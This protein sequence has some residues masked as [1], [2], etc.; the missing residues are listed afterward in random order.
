MYGTT[1][2]N[3]SIDSDIAVNQPKKNYSYYFIVGVVALIGLLG[4]TTYSAGFVS[5]SSSK[6]ISAPINQHNYLSSN[7]LKVTATNE[8]G[9]FSAPYPWMDDVDG[10][11]LV[12]PYK[13][14]TLTLSGSYIEDQ[15]YTYVWEID[16]FEYKPVGSSVVITGPVPGK[17]TVKVNALDDSKSIV[18]TYT[19]LLVSKYVKREI[20]SLTVADR[21]KM[22]DAAY[23]MWAYDQETGVAKYG[24][25]FTSIEKFVQIHSAASNDIMCDQFHEGTG[26]IT[27]HLAMGLA[28]EA[29]LRAVDPSVTLPYWD[30]TIEGEKIQNAGQN[31]S[32]F[33]EFSPA[34]TADWFGSV[35]DDNHIQDGRWAHT[36]MPLAPDDETTQNSYGFIRSYWNNNPDPEISR[37]LFDAC[38][39]EP[40]HKAIPACKTHLAILNG[41]SLGMFQLLSPG[42]GHG[43]MHV[44]IGGVWGGCTEAYSAFQAKWGDLLR[45]TLSDSEIEATGLDLRSFK[46]KWGETE[47]R[48]TMIEKA[49]MG[50]Y[51]H[52]YRSFWRS[53]MCA[54][55]NTPAL[56]ECPESCDVD[57]TPFEECAC[58]VN[59]LTNGETDWENLFPCVLNSESNRDYFNKTM[60]TELLKDLTTFLATSSVLEG[61]MIESAST[62]DISFWM[63]HPVIERLLAAKRLPTV[64]KMGSKEFNKWAVVDGSAETW[65]EY[66]FYNL[67]AGAN[68]YH[69]E[70]YTCYGHASDDPVIPGDQSLPYPDAIASIADTDGDGVVSNWEFYIAL[71]PNNIDGSDYVFDNFEWDHCE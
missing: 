20:R 12:E 71:D 67:E 46:N 4:Y 41:N 14:T 29:S 35:D 64:T 19:T 27:H 30:F 31:P 18:A 15:S 17:Y 37:H 24:S 16:S 42:D 33:M 61:E 56:L 62:A 34:F 9:V 68:S 39:A 51:F 59:A 44:Q 47:Q 8:Y 3:L 49:I 55:D 13:S 70:A 32:Y 54:I 69:P 11:F 38:G 2:T 28:F 53:H 23:Q 40:Y 26:F 1:P 52:I 36:A 60:P 63:I 21:E 7:E 65:L 25:Q 58:N 50:E 22:L 48:Q 5:S 57:S 66:S 6:F 10:T 43:P 45:T